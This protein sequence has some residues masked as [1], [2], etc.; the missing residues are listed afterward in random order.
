GRLAAW[1]GFTLPSAISLDPFLRSASPAMAI[2]VSGWIQRGDWLLG[3]ASRCRL[4]LALIL[5]CARH[6]QLWRFTS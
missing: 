5:F 2:Y 1:A 6:L 3:L 4:P